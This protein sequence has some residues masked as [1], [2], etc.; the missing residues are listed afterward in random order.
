MA[1][2]VGDAV[3]SDAT[4]LGLLLFNNWSKKLYGYVKVGKMCGIEMGKHAG[5]W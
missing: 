3:D 5:R 4:Q 2:R 1:E